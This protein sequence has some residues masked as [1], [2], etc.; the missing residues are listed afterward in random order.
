MQKRAEP[1]PNLPVG[2]WPL[3]DGRT[4][5]RVWAP[6]A[7]KLELHLVNSKWEVVLASSDEK[8]GGTTTLAGRT[9]TPAS[10][11]ELASRSAVLTRR[12]RFG[13]AALPASVR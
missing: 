10:G 8:W 3:A 9:F 13:Q 7:E 11:V 1:D 4:E 2:A 12:R 5:F 6:Y